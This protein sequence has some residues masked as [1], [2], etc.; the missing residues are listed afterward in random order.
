MNDDG[1]ERRLRLGGSFYT[2]QGLRNDQL[3]DYEPIGGNA[4]LGF[5]IASVP[6]PSSLTL[7]ALGGVVVALRRRR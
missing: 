7:V 6:E 2:D 5:R 1:A 4:L 3:L